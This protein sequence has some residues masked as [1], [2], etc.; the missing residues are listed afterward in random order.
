MKEIKLD[1]NKHELALILKQNKKQG[2]DSYLP[3]STEI[4]ISFINFICVDYLDV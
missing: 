4:K 2:T 1:L 3:K